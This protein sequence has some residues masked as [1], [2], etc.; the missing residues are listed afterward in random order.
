VTLRLVGPTSTRRNR[1]ELFLER[2]SRALALGQEEDDV[3]VRQ[4]SDGVGQG[5]LRG[6]VQPLDVIEGDQ[7]GVDA[8]H[9]ALR[10]Q[11]AERDGAWL[12][13]ID[14]VRP[15]ERDVERP[16]LRWRQGREIVVT[17][18]VEEVDQR[19]ERQPGLRAAR[20]GS[21][22]PPPL[23]VR[24]GDT[25]LP[26]ARLSDPRLALENHCRGTALVAGQQLGDACLLGLSRHEAALRAFG[27]HPPSLTGSSITTAS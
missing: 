3:L 27:G 13:R 12:G 7:Q 24:E 16:Q 19:G 14:R 21:K 10:R 11:H 4:T 1:P 25:A 18:L 5:L 26:Q 6:P 20:P 2:G 9:A 15:V 22:H 23:G 8:R 17:N